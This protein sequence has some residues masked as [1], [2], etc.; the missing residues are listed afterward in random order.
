MKDILKATVYYTYTN[1]HVRFVVAI[2]RE[3][4]DIVVSS[5]LLSLTQSVQTVP[6]LD[7]KGGPSES[8]EGS[9]G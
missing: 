5:S 7:Q 9:C 8:S 6:D 3:N 4:S 2:L 1:K